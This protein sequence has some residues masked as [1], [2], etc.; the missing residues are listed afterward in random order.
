RKP[1]PMLRTMDL[2]IADHG[3][4]ARR[5]QAAQIAVALFADAAELV[6]APA[7]VLLWNK[8]N[9]RREVTPRSECFGIGNAR[10]QSRGQRRTDPR[11]RIEPLCRFICPMPSHD[12]AVEGQYL[13]F[14]CHQLSAQGG[15]AGAR[16][17]GKP[18]IFDIGNDLQK[19]LDAVASNRRHDPELGKM[20]ADRVESY[21]GDWVT[22]SIRRRGEP[23]FR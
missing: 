7:R 6:F 17:F 10:D 5:E 19:L 23:A 2:R 3:K 16:Y 4:R 13:G 11:G 8:P 18:L 15:N 12:A 1:G 20:G 14:Q 21:A 9:P 22:M